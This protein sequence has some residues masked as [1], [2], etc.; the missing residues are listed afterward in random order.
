MVTQATRWTG[1]LAIA[2]MWALAGCGQLPEVEDAPTPP[3]VASAPPVAAPAAAPTDSAATASAPAAAPAAT[4]PAAASAPAVA[5]PAPVAAPAATDEDLATLPPLE[6]VSDPLQR[7]FETARRA[8]LQARGELAA[9]QFARLAEDVD[10]ARAALER[11]VPQLPA[12]GVPA[13]AGATALATLR[14]EN[15]GTPEAF[16]ALLA[17]VAEARGPLGFGYTH[18]AP[19]LPTPA[20]ATVPAPG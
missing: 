20:P 4:A 5:P 15:P 17:Q 9:K 13:A 1:L 2:G 8:L 14:R 3:P 10:V 12:G 11:A 16:A 6:S 19:A 18:P 7:D